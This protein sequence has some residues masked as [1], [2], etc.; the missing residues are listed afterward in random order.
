M[1]VAHFM[2]RDRR[3]EDELVRQQAGRFTVETMTDGVMVAIDEL[4]RSS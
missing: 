4:R 1:S 2:Q 3:D